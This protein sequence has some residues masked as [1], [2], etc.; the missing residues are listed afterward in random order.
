M[1]NDERVARIEAELPGDWYR[2]TAGAR[3][4]EWN[5]A[6]RRAGVSPTPEAA[7]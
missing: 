5:A 1:T 7:R 2:M 3:A 4:A 6:A